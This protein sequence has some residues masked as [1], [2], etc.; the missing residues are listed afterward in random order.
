LATAILYRVT[1]FHTFDNDGDAKHL[2]LL[3]LSG[4][5]GG[6]RLLICKPQA[7]NPSL[8]L[9]RSAQKAA[10]PGLPTTPSNPGG[11]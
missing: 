3:P 4:N 5:V 9:R 1:E 2:G 6:N 8:D 7:R 10:L 11:S